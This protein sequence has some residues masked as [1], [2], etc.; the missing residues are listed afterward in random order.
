MSMTT[1]LSGLIAAQQDI[2]ITSHN[3]ANVGTN[4]FRKS[5][6]EFVDDYYTTPMDSHRTVVGSGTHMSRVAVQFDQG[7]FAAT[8]QTLDLAIQGPGFFAVTPMVNN[9]G[10]PTELVYSRNGSFSLDADSRIVDSAGRPMLTWPVAMDG[11]NLQETQDALQTVTIPM[12]K[13]DAVASD[14]VA[15]SLQFPADD[16]MMGMQDAV[17]ATNAFD[18]ED[19]TSY[20]FQ[21][22][23]PMTDDNGNAVEARVYFTKIAEPD[24]LSEFTEYQ[25]HLMVDGNIVPEADPLNPTTFRFDGEGIMDDATSL[26]SFAGAGGATYDIDLTGSEMENGTFSVQSASH[27][28]QSPEGLSSLEVDPRGVIW[29][30]YGTDNRVALGRVALANFSNPQGLRQD[31]NA[32]FF[33]SSESG[34]PTLTSPGDKG[35]GLLQSGMLERSNVDLTEELV[36]LITAQRNYQANAKAMETSSSLMQTIMNIR[37]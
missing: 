35:L 34:D 5:R 22:A 23:I 8:G 17:P 16:A 28:G 19:D 21:T 29:A 24:P 31:G 36:Q 7:N 1:A 32:S 25:A 4:A 11:T 26:L 13:G 9:A 37:S 3:I 15:L 12:I 27:N 30:N 10:D 20:A 33:A 18:P 14:E 6:A 2:S